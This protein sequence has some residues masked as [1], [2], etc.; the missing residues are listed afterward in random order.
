MEIED[1]QIELVMYTSEEI[2][3]KVKLKYSSEKLSFY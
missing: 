1:K 2:N 3:F